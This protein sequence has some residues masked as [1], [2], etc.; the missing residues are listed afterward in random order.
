MKWIMR[1]GTFFTVCNSFLVG[2]EMAYPSTPTL[3]LS[4]RGLEHVLVQLL[5]RVR[6]PL[7][8]GVPDSGQKDGA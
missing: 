8:D 2:M 7:P 1:A 6:L 4:V 3:Y 5:C